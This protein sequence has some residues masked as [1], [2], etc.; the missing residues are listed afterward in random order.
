MSLYVF[1]T[2]II[3]SYKKINIK[4]Y[5]ILYNFYMKY[6]FMQRL[7]KLSCYMIILIIL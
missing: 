4:L 6:F 3:T 7:R 2:Y 5:P 1:Y